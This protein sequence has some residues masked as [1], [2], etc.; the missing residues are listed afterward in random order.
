MTKRYRKWILWIAAVAVFGAVAVAY[1]LLYLHRQLPGWA[2]GEA[3]EIKYVGMITNDNTDI[4]DAAGR[5]VTDAIGLEWWPPHD[6]MGLGRCFV[7]DV[8]EADRDII[9][10]PQLK[11]SQAGN[12]KRSIGSWGDSLSA[13]T[14]TGRR[15]YQNAGI[16]NKYTLWLPANTRGLRWFDRSVTVQEVD[17]TVGY[18][19]GP[20]GKA[21]LTF[22]GPFTSGRTA[23]AGSGTLSI[24]KTY[25]VDSRFGSLCSLNTPIGID[26]PHRVLAYDRAG[27]RY[28]VRY[29]TL[30]SGTAGASGRFTVDGLAPEEIAAVTVNEEERQRTF[31]NVSLMPIDPPA[32]ADGYLARIARRAGIAKPASVQAFSNQLE[33]DRELVLKTVDLL[34][35]DNIRASEFTLFKM[36]PADLAVLPAQDRERLLSTL[37]RWAQ[38]DDA[39]IRA[40]GLRAGLTVAFRQFAA[41]TLKTLI[42]DFCEGQ[43]PGRDSSWM[44]DWLTTCLEKHLSEFAADDVRT[45]RDALLEGRCPKGLV[46]EFVYLLKACPLDEA[47]SALVDLANDERPWLWRKPL[48]EPKVLAALGPADSWPRALKVKRAIASRFAPETVSD[49]QIAGEARSLLP[50]LLTDDLAARDPGV[51][52]GI[53]NAVMSQCDR[54]TASHTAFAFIGGTREYAGAGDGIGVMIRYLNLWNGVD[55]AGLGSDVAKDSPC[56][57]LVNW[58]EV[59]EQFIEWRA[60]G[61]VAPQRRREGRVS[62][63]DF[64]VIV[65][66]GEDKENALIDIWSEADDAQAVGRVHVTGHGENF[67]AYS[68]SPALWPGTMSTGPGSYDHEIQCRV[69]A[70]GYV[71]PLNMQPEFALPAKP[72]RQVRMFGGFNRNVFIEAAELPESVLSGTKVF[73]EWWKA[74][75][76]AIESTGR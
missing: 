11:V 30:G 58:R 66:N 19:R 72:S 61:K 41:P 27:R 64:R 34:R 69:Y 12:V 56:A 6:S 31:H 29:T 3:T 23:F 44:V 4:Y 37:E 51:F 18:W 26:Y 40:T 62:A 71:L 60:S 67:A 50:T 57:R 21:A 70:D 39:F 42:E 45:I 13:A 24:L 49:A 1:S 16:D 48:Q 63:G 76:P 28:S 74:H 15:L 38:A 47:T 59:C 35:G 20:R 75:G 43:T 36:T 46:P 68:I 32:P 8:A 53:A 52:A 2:T 73:D 14:P 9:F 22:Q 54:E 10:A 65:V 33:N 55:V 17:V 5:R 25:G 7:F